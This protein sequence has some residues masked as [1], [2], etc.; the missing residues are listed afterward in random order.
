[1]THANMC[2]NPSLPTSVAHTTIDIINHPV[3]S[4]THRRMAAV[5]NMPT[6]RPE[7][8]KEFTGVVMSQF[9]VHGSGDGPITFFR[10][11]HYPSLIQKRL[12]GQL[13][14]NANFGPNVINVT[15]GQVGVSLNCDAVSPWAR[16][17]CA[18]PADIL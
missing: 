7:I 5:D 13:P 14:P 3:R 1:M 10:R 18:T 6:G 15:A 8:K 17:D 4:L 16:I 12:N 9:D 2:I 11:S